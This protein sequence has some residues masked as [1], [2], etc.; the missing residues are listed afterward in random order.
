MGIYLFSLF[1]LLVLSSP[2]AAQKKQIYPT[3]RYLQFGDSIAWANPDYDHQGWALWATAQYAGNFWQ[4]FVITIDSGGFKFDHP[5]LHVISHGSYEVYW[6]G[7]KIG[8]SGQVGS[9][10]EEE[11]PGRFT[12]NV[13]VPNE[14]VTPG[15]HIVAFRLSNHHSP[16]KRVGTWNN[17]FL[18]EFQAERQRLLLL[19]AKIFVLAG[20][21]LMAGL[22]YFFLYFFRKNALVGKVFSVL[23]FLFFALVVMEYYKFLVLYLYPFH[24][25]RLMVIL[26]LTFSISYLTPLFFLLYYKLP[27]QK[28]I[29][30]IYFIVLIFLAIYN[31]PGTD[32]ANQSLTECMLYSSFA[33]AAWA[34]WLGRKESKLIFFALLLAK[35]LVDFNHI[36]FSINMF[37]YDINLFLGFSILVIAMMYLL[38]R[39]TIEDRSAY[40]ASLT[41][42]SRLQNELLKKNIQPHFLMNTLTSL[43]EWIEEAPQKSIEFIEALAEE[44]HIFSRIA[45]QKLIPV[46][47]EIKLCK[48]H[49]EIM[50]FRK[51]MGYALRTEGIDP[52][53][54]IPPA[55]LHTLV[56]NAITHSA[57]NQEEDLMIELKFVREKDSKA[58]ILTTFGPIHQNN[59][60]G[61]GTGLKYIKSRLKESYGD[62]WMVESGPTTN[63]WETKISILEN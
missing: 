48:Q 1:T 3:E 23:C 33:I 57:P 39:R 41:L 22:Y 5:G 56:E 13:L 9:S 7:I 62:Q 51:E 8:E 60:K 26:G 19:T 47:E 25:T 24:F 40:E 43:M 17:F 61:S 32:D 29:A 45:D 46:E 12:S 54:R 4:R 55:I 14:L 35:L 36:P 59:G 44:F 6:D 42:S 34:I 38:A 30:S 31:S 28:W 37:S 49:L 50:R 58:Y 52:T 15:K 11:I 63:G 21:F 20:I 18:E 2:V 10:K 16:N 53:E 27:Y